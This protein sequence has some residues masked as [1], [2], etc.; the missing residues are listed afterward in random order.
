MALTAVSDLYRTE[1]GDIV[2]R[3]VICEAEWGTAKKETGN[4]PLAQRPGGPQR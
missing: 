3:G 1:H 4:A 2:Y